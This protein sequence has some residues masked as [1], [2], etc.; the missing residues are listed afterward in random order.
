MRFD[1]ELA[2]KVIQG[3]SGSLIVGSLSNSHQG[4]R[5]AVI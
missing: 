1:A 4:I 5:T 2:Q 3:E